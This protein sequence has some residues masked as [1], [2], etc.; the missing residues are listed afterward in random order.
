[1][2]TSATSLA[3]GG[4]QDASKTQVLK[5]P[6][7]ANT[8]KAVLWAA[9]EAAQNW[10][11]LP[12]FAGLPADVLARV[13]GVLEP[14][15]LQL[16][17]TLM[18]Q[19]DQGDALYILESGTLRITFEAPDGQVAVERTIEAP[20]VVGEMALVTGEN[21]SATVTAAVASRVLRMEK[22][23]FE[24]LCREHPYTAI[25]LTCLVGERLLENKG[26]RRV[27]KYQVVGRLGSGG[28]ATVF[29][30]IHPGLGHAVALKMLSHALVFDPSFAD[31][32]GREGRLVAQ[33][34]HDNIVRVL[35]TEEAYGTRFIVMEK[36][37]GDVLDHIVKRGEKLPWSQV[38]RILIEIAEALAY[39]HARGLV[40]RDIKPAN[41]FM[42]E[43]KRVKLLDFGIAV[44]TDM[45][46]DDEG[47]I[48]GTPYYMSPEQI[49]GHQLDGR[50][51]LY[52]LGILT[53]ELCTHELP[54]VADTV[55][56]V[57]SKQLTQDVPDPRLLDPDIPDD[58]VEFITHCTAKRKE[59]RYSCAAEAADS[60][61][62]SGDFNSADP[63]EM[64]N[65]SIN[66]LPSRRV[67]VQQ[68]IREAMERL[69]KLRGVRVFGSHEVEDRTSEEAQ[70]R[71]P[72]SKGDAV[73]I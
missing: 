62:L 63:V 36:L 70:P 6:Q 7:F 19:G 13:V 47:K 24:R 2:S 52:S 61:R 18:K 32:F 17:E 28:M 71:A 16:G 55:Q 50:S 58:I 15:E 39:S 69:N 57:F 44:E 5:R 4:N 43:D 29:E 14:A 49:L 31:H 64:S 12:A 22:P 40:H 48:I 21:R 27:G 20:A 10:M 9:E 60:L 56:G 54:F 11:E 37:S 65:I 73:E 45:A 35:D 26:I 67:Q 23:E 66:Y 30:A 72:R 3:N 68:I 59:E 53:F 38:R 8:V 42:T 51:D 1:M 41:V 34:N 46:L 25:F 33:L